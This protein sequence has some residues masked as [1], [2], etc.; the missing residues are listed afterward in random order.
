MARE[1][2]PEA[3]HSLLIKADPD[4][5]AAVHPNNI[6]RII[7][8]LE[9]LRHPPKEEDRVSSH[10]PW[11]SVCYLGL[12]TETPVLAA[13]I[14][15]RVDDMMKRGLLAEVEALR[16]QYPCWS[17]TA[18]QA[19]GYKELLAHMAGE[20]TL[21]E[22][23][24]NVKLRTRQYAKRQMTWFR[25]EQDILWVSVDEDDTITKIA[26]KLTNILIESFTDLV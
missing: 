2:G 8:A 23:V 1:Q 7:R 18:R 17:A 24:A 6:K 10:R 21:A 12:K 14:N 19:I 16:Q 9:V 22:A 26:E 15:R 25:R 11:S 4:R 5:A 13:R 3:L 20:C